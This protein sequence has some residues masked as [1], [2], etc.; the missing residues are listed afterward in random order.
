MFVI[1]SG[2][3]IMAVGTSR[4]KIEA[5]VQDDPVSRVHP[6]TI[7]TRGRSVPMRARVAVKA[8]SGSPRPR[9]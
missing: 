2:G 5:I 6:T 3:L 1:E 8:A 4:G 9:A 7:P